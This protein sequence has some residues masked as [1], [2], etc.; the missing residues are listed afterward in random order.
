M[1]DIGFQ[2]LV[3][4]FVIALLVFGPEKLPEVGRTLGKWMIEIRRGMPSP[5]RRSRK[6]RTV[7]PRGRKGRDRWKIQR[8]P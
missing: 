2:E 8:C 1:F 7:Y 6:D 3:V 4:I 5:R